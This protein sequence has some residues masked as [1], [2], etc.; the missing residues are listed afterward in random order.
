MLFQTIH[1]NSIVLECKLTDQLNRIK[2]PEVN[3]HLYEELLYDMEIK[4]ITIN[5]GETRQL[6]AEE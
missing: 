3:P 6:D 1:C 4:R 5:V 2:R